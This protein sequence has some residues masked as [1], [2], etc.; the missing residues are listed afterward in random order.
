MRSGRYVSAVKNMFVHIGF[1]FSL[2]VCYLVVGLLSFSGLKKTNLIGNKTGCFIYRF[3]RLK[4]KICHNLKYA[5]GDSLSQHQRNEIAED[6]VRN[7][8]KNWAEILYACGPFTKKLHE[9]IA[10]EEKKKKK[11]ALERG[12]GVLAVSAHIGNYGMIGSRLTKEGYNFLMVIKDVKSAVGSRLYRWGRKHT[13]LL[14][15]ATAPE[16]NFFKATIK[17]LKANGIV[18]LIADEN[19]R[20]GGIFVDF[21]SHPASTAP[22]PAALALRTGAPVVPVF[23]LR[24]SDNSHKIIIEK[25]IKCEITG[26]RDQ[27]M[28]NITSQYTKVIEQYIKSDP[29]QWLWTNWRWRTQPWGQSDDAKIKKKKK[30]YAIKK[31]FSNI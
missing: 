3:S 14:S 6:V 18:C 8:A 21:F 17:T 2:P 26:E 27:D 13:G 20:H 31:Y 16:R 7:L 10:I 12:K 11:K 23:I 4:V 25:E 15:V 28:L 22:G 5:Y 29:T 9:N 1:C 24:N 30:F 19:K